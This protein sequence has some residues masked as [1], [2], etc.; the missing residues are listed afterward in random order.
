MKMY[1]PSMVLAVLATLALLALGAASEQVNPWLQ[2]QPNGTTGGEL[3]RLLTA[4]IAHLNLTHAALN[5][6]AL[7]LILLWLGEQYH[8]WEWWLAGTFISVCISISL[9]YWN[10]E[11]GYYVG[12]SGTLHGLLIYGL[13]PLCLQKSLSA[14]LALLVIGGKIITEQ[15]YPASSQHTAELINGAVITDAH[16]YGAAWGAAAVAIR[17]AGVML[18]GKKNNRIKLADKSS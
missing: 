15:L 3:W 16:L 10:P 18:G 5:L 7:W 6:A 4:H 9:W 13:A 11:L 8:A 2:Y 1:P 12:L 17:Y 14:W